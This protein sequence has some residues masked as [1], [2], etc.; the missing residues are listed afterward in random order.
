MF[1][2]A[3][4]QSEDTQAQP[5]IQAGESARYRAMAPRASVSACDDLQFEVIIETLA[6]AESHLRSAGEAGWRG[7]RFSLGTHI[8]Q[9]RLSA[10][11]AIQIFEGLGQHHG[12]EIQTRAV[13]R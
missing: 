8:Q 12:G 1:C 4:E 9:V 10:I 11:T 7:D 6:L 5:R 3:A 2:S 13:A